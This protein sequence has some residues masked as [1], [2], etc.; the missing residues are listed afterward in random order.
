MGGLGKLL[1]VS[2]VGDYIPWLAW[3]NSFT[4]LDAKVDKAAK[5]MDEFLEGVVEERMNCCR[6][7]N[8]GSGSCDS[9]ET[10][11]FIDI[12]LEIQR[13]NATGCSPVH[14]DTVK[15]LILDMLGAGTD[16]TSAALVW[17]MAELLTHPQ[18]MK[19]LQHD[20]RE[21]AS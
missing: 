20:V 12:P 8:G 3:I 14:R 13:E 1:G 2:N 18:V 17:T 5:G 21:I 6:Q 9:E 19:K 10:Q 11:G 4:G 7:E 16:T 15:A